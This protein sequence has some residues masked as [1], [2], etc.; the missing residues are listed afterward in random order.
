MPLNIKLYDS[1]TD[2][3]DHLIR[4]ASAANSGEWSM[5]VCCRMFQQTLDGSARGW[6]EWLPHNSIDEWEDLREA[7]ASRY[8]V[9]RAC[10]KEPHE[11]TKIIR[12]ANESLTSFKER[13]MVETGFIIF[14]ENLVPKIKG[15]LDGSSRI[16]RRNIETGGEDRVGRLK[17]L[18]SIPSTIHSMMKFLTPKGV[19]TLVTQTVIITKCRHLENKQMIEEENVEGDKE[20]SMTEEVLENPSFPDQLVTIGGGLS[21]ACKDQLKYLLQS[22]MEPSDMTGVPG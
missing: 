5:L 19:A 13:W 21:E 20:V 10:I 4:F 14:V 3:E 12:K 22:N 7:F 16:C 9:M 1:T 6:F 15:M 17:M 2:P 8:S 18:R 11:I